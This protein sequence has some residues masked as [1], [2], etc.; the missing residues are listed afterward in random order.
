MVDRE[1]NIIDVIKKFVNERLDLIC[2]KR[3]TFITTLNLTIWMVRNE[4]YSIIF[5]YDFIR[6]LG[7]AIAATAEC[8][9]FMY[10]IKAFRHGP[11][12]YDCWVMQ[13]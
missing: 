2:W 5:R 3:T 12:A 8:A 1:T 10:W 11:T 4:F 13:Y 9:I 6:Y 7:S